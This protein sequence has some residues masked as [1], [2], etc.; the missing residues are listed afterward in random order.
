M[1]DKLRGSAL[2]SVPF[3]DRG[4]VIRLLD[5]LP[6]MDERTRAAYDE[7]LMTVLSACVLQERFKLAA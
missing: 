2:A 1:Q 7:V 6:S 3:F 4:K 5:N